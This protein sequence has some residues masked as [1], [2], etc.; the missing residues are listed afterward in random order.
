[1]RVIVTGSGGFIGRQLVRALLAAGHLK[2]ASGTACPIEKLA[3]IDVQHVDGLSDTRIEQFT[4]D[5]ADEATMR[6]IADFA[7]TSVFHLAAVLTTEAERDPARA[8]AVNVSALANILAASASKG[9]PV[10]VYPSS[11]AAFGGALPDVIDDDFPQHPQTSYGTHKSIAELMLADATRHRQI[12][13]R[14]LRLPIILTRPGAPSPAVS[15]RVASLIRDV[16]KGIDITCPFKPDSRLPLA[17]VQKVAQSLIRLH[18]APRTAFTSSIAMNLPALTI[19]VAD[20]VDG[21][22]RAG[23]NRK[24]GNV[25]FQPNAELQRIIDSWPRGFVSTRAA[26]AGIAAHGSF[27]EIVADYLASVRESS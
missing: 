12:D 1:M 27:D 2:D 23:H 22:R 26:S 16:L 24:L 15:D 11:I 13:G 10:F 4:G 20:M 17:S 25:V 19:S 18:D 14:A 9:R 21:V 3:L 6:F 8:M 7:P 5:I